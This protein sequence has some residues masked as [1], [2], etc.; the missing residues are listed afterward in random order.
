MIAD[1]SIDQLQRDVQEQAIRMIAMRQPMAHDLRHAVS[2][3]KLAAEL[4]RIGDLAKNIALRAMT[5]SGAEQPRTILVGL[6]HMTELAGRQLKDVLDAWSARDGK[7]A[8]GVWRGDAG[9]DALYNSVFRDLLARM[10]EDPRD[11]EHSTHL[12]FVAKNLE[13]IGDH[14]TNI[15]E[16]ILYLITGVTSPRDRIKG[17]DTSTFSTQETAT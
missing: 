4:E 7:K 16:Q 6:E 8:L 5:I 2:V 15:A 12:L 17:D 3:L 10:M 9:L 1:G 11:I 13:R 14:T